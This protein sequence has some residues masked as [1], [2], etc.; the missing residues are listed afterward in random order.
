MKAML[1]NS[2]G[3]IKLEVI[4]EWER[5]NE[6]GYTEIDTLILWILHVKFGFGK[7]RLR[8][9]FETYL[10]EAIEMQGRYGDSYVYKMQS[11]L[12]KIG[13]DVVEWEKE[14]K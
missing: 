3:R 4:K 12:K 9:Y 2:Q 1:P 8:R 5:Q 10:H 13:V 7:I 6:E 11:E 14:I